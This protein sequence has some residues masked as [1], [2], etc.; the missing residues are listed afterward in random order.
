[1]K[2]LIT[3][4]NNI[5]RRFKSF[6]SSKPVIENKVTLSDQQVNEIVRKILAQLQSILQGKTIEQIK[7]VPQVQEVI[8]RYKNTVIPVIN[9]DTGMEVNIRN[10]KTQVS[11]E[12]ID[13]IANSLSKVLGV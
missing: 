8:K 6:K 2:I 13:N 10:V 1:M 9:R 4:K 7:Q 3:K 11:E 12:E 5:P